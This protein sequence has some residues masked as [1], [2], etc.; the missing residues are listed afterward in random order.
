MSVPL[1]NSECPKAV[2][3]HN[4]SCPKAVPKHNLLCSL[5]PK[6]A[7]EH[8]SHHPLVVHKDLGLSTHLV[9]IMQDIL[10]NNPCWFYYG[11]SHYI[12]Q[13]QPLSK[14]DLCNVM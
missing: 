7:P 9:P 12:S 5:C 10:N 11:D 3:E 8:I 2:L 13:L 14:T 6:A 1:Y 4:I